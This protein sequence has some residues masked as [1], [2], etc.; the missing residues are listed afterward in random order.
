[1][2][3][4]TLNGAPLCDDLDFGSNHLLDIDEK[5]SAFE[6]FLSGNRALSLTSDS[7]NVIKW[8]HVELHPGRLRTELSPYF[9]N[10]LLDGNT[11]NFSCPE[12]GLK[13]MSQNSMVHDGSTFLEATSLIEEDSVFLEHSFIVHDNLVSSQIALDDAQMSANESRE[14]LSSTSFLTSSFNTEA[15]TSREAESQLPTLQL[16]SY[17]TITSLGELPD[18]QYLRSIYPQTPTPNLLCALVA[19]IEKRQ[20]SVKK[21][22]YV[23]DLYDLIVGDDTRPSFKI[24][25]WFRP[26]HATRPSRNLAQD[27]LRSTLDA[28]RTGDMLLMRYIALSIYRNEVFGQ[29]LNANISKASTL[30]EPLSRPD[31]TPIYKHVCPIAVE[32]K[33]LNVKKWSRSRIATHN[34]GSQKRKATSSMKDAKTKRKLRSQRSTDTLPPDTLEAA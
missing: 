23:M 10:S 21:G 6:A 7:S 34:E 1:M 14:S 31:G 18:A 29:S 26:I 19:P 28:V 4:K 25:F 33:L 22:R 15:S 30:V 27:K 20:V 8:R 24:S 3:L 2:R 16:P 32:E 5:D 9:P 17:L 13:S 11:S 12:I